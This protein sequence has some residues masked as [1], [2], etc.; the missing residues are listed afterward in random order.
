MHSVC[1]RGGRAADNRVTGPVAHR[2]NAPVSVLPLR[3][4]RL[5]LR[6]MDLADAAVLAAYR[7]D[8]HVARCRTGSCR[9]T[10]AVR[11]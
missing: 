4:A 8:P 5:A 2:L 7:S 1:A 11:P 6:V 9:T 3:T 10:P